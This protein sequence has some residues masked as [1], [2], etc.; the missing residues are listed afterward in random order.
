M[1]LYFIAP[2]LC[3]LITSTSHFLFSLKFCH[4]QRAGCDWCCSPNL[5]NLHRW[6]QHSLI[7]SFLYSGDS[8]DGFADVSVWNPGSRPDLL[9]K[10]DGP[11]KFF[12]HPNPSRGECIFYAG[13]RHSHEFFCNLQEIQQL[14]R[15]IRSMKMATLITSYISLSQI[16]ANSIRTLMSILLELSLI[17]TSNPLSIHSEIINPL[18]VQLHSSI[19]SFFAIVSP[20]IF[21][22]YVLQISIFVRVRGEATANRCVYF[23]SL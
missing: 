11:G 13:L 2:A 9:V 16:P 23:F 12:G 14:E 15:I 6:S 17:R 8:C 18:T 1:I 5:T 19:L 20:R 21:L 3:T 22:S 10:I 7:S 4:G